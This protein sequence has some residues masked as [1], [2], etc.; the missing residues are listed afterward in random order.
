M[1][2]A[3]HPRLCAEEATVRGADT[4]QFHAKGDHTWWELKQCDSV[5][6]KWEATVE[7]WQVFSQTCGLHQNRDEIAGTCRTAIT[8]N[9]V[10]P[11]PKRS[12]CRN[13]LKFKTVAVNNLRG[14]GPNMGDEG[15]MRFAETLPGVDL[16]VKANQNYVPYNAAKN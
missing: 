12:A 14:V 4:F 11:R 15:H 2:F 3:I 1:D 10:F 5:D 16:I 8:G 7:N 13:A 6:M 9:L